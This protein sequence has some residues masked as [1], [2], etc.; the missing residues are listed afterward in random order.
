MKARLSVLVVAMILA[1]C[2]SG[3]GATHTA[4]V[5]PTATPAEATTTPAAPNLC[6]IEFGTG[7]DAVTTIVYT[8]IAADSTDC[9]NILWKG[10]AESGGA[11]VVPLPSGQP[12]C[13]WHPN[14]EMVFGGAAAARSCALDAAANPT[15]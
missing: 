9:A 6:A 10:E 13:R 8:D 1:A 7:A 4:P 11:R 14:G 5:V 15:P 12:V 2:S 3:P